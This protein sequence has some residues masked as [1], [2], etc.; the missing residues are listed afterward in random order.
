MSFEFGPKLNSITTRFSTRDPNNLLNKQGG[1]I[2][3]VVFS[4]ELIDQNSV[5]GDTLMEKGT[6]CG[7]SVEVYRTPEEANVRND[8]LA[9]FDGGAFSSG[10]HTVVG[11]VIV[12]TSYQ[13]TAS[14]QSALESSIIEELTSLE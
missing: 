12:R 5:Y 2:A 9:L 11:T 7:G 6:E 1:Y 13:L 4:S 3:F 8:Y 10:S 14:Q